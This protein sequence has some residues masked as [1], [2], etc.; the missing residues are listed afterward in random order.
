MKTQLSGDNTSIAQLPDENGMF[1]V[2]GGRFVS[3]VLMEQ[4]STNWESNTIV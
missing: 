3:E 4:H 2:Y 1:G